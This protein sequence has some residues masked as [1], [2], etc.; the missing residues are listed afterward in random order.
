M[1]RENIKIGQDMTLVSKGIT[2]S[3]YG[4]DWIDTDQVGATSFLRVTRVGKKY[5]YGIHY[6]NEDGQRKEAYYESKHDL[7]DYLV[8]AGLREDLEKQYRE[9]RRAR[10]EYEKQKERARYEIQ[11]KYSE[12]ERAEFDSWEKAHPRLASINLAEIQELKVE[13][14]QLF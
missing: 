3:E 5:L 9:Y 4:G 8:L 1:N 13:S 11:R 6:W 14:V 7:N 12:L 10:D 2:H